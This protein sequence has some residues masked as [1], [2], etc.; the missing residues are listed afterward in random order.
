[1]YT[2]PLGTAVNG[3]FI[4]GYAIPIGTD[5][6]ANFILAEFVAPILYSNFLVFC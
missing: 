1:M 4:T 2:P 5:V 6:Q 3:V